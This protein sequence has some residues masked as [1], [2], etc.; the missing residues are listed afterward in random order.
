M[1]TSHL[2]PRQYWAEVKANPNRAKFGFGEKAALINIDLQRA[3]TD[4]NAFPTVYE[5]HPKQLEYVNA[6]AALARRKNMAAEFGDRCSNSSSAPRPAVSKNTC[7]SPTRTIAR[8]IATFIAPSSVVAVPPA[9]LPSLPLEAQQRYG[10][11]TCAA[12]KRRVHEP[13]R[14]W[15]RRRL[16]QLSSSVA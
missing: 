11:T 4:T 5:T 3:Y 9:N 2:T 15:R 6:L 13:P 12:A 8:L 16:R 14:Q 10:R 7:R 1:Q